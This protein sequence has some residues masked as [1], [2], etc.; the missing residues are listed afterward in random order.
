MNP[1]F[2]PMQTNNI[3]Y[4]YFIYRFIKTFRFTPEKYGSY[5]YIYRYIGLQMDRY[6]IYRDMTHIP[7]NMYMYIYIY[8][9]I[10]INI[11]IYSYKYIY[12]YIPFTIIDLQDDIN[13]NPSPKKPKARLPDVVAPDHV[14]RGLRQ[15][16]LLEDAGLVG[17]RLLLLRAA[18]A[19]PGRC[20]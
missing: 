15:Q 14:Q 4:T 5:I 8:I 10:A 16:L 19:V 11:Y 12:T 7:I 17:R 18:G 2:N 1:I 9:H 13:P 3:L 20:R 6:M